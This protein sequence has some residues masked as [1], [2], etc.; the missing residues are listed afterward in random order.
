MAVRAPKVP[1]NMFFIIIGVIC[2]LGM[3]MISTP[4]VAR[5]NYS[6]NNYKSS[7][8][9]YIDSCGELVIGNEIKINA[10]DLIIIAE[11]LADE[12]SRIEKIGE[13]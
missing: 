7:I 2:T 8:V 1:I 9:N 6:K 5:A 13:E 12:K 10:N 3:K 11:K 4:I